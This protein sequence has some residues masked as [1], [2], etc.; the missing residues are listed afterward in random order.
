MPL[1]LVRYLAALV[2]RS[3]AAALAVL[4]LLYASVDLVEAGSIAGVDAGTLLA[5]YAM[6]LPHITAQLLPMALA[7]GAVV[8][9]AGLRRH[10]EWNAMALTGI[11][12]ARI[13]GAMLAVPLLASI[14]ALLLSF[15][16][17]PAAMAGYE[18][19]LGIEP[20]PAAGWSLLKDG[21][22]SRQSS[23][24]GAGGNLRVDIGPSGEVLRWRTVGPH[25]VSWI[26][27]RGA[28]FSRGRSEEIDGDLREAP[29]LV[30]PSAGMDGMVAS[31][32]SSSA[33]RDLAGKLE[34]AGLDP[35]PVR[36]QLALRTALV[37]A[38]VIVPALA[39]F[40]AL[41]GSTHR[42]SRLLPMAL[43]VCAFYWANVVVAWNGALWGAWGAWVLA[44]G[45]PAL[46]AAGVTAQLALLASWK[47]AV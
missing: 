19:A 42:I 35:R 37:L 29:I 21:G 43:A 30:M 18:K 10:G 27:E 3:S 13:G 33:L 28:G 20:V 46:G 34:A 38:C 14:P 31:S 24:E 11:S 40:L 7:F 9:L 16:L 47:K 15:I 1:K 44:W 39:V 5:A 17:A 12:P 22:I 45:V 25:G 36:A 32:W 6:K 8:A 4:L 26:W 41:F 2:A 23:G